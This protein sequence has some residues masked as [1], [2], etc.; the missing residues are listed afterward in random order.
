MVHFRFYMYII[1]QLEI[2]KSK[3]E[4]Y[5]FIIYKA[6]KGE[7]CNNIAYQLNRMRIATTK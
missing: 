6:L 4:L 2:D 7:T 1:E 5:R 3:V